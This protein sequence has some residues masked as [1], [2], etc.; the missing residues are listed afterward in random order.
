MEYLKDLRATMSF[1]NNTFEI[2]RLR[3]YVLD[4]A[5]YG[6]NI[7]FNLADMKKQNMEFN[8]VLDVTNVDIGKLDEQEAAKK[9]RDAEL[10]LN[11]NFKGHGLDI[12]RELSME[13]FINIHKIGDKFANRLLKGLSTEK[14]QSKLGAIGQF[15]VDNSMNVTGFRFNLDKGLVY[16]TVTFSRRTFGYLLG[17]KNERVEFERMPIQEYLRKVQTGD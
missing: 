8:L 5:L 17:V 11:A 3:A 9:K 1:R 2:A 10:S 13:G 7:L 14:G 12:S 6:R 4:G 16:A 15:A